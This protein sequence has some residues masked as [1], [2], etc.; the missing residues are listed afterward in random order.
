MEQEKQKTTCSGT[1]EQREFHQACSRAGLI[2][3]CYARLCVPPT[4][5]TPPKWRSCWVLT[6]LL[7]VLQ[8]VCITWSVTLVLSTPRLYV[9][10][11][12][13]Y[14]L[15]YFI[16]ISLHPCE[17]EKKF[18]CDH[19]RKRK[20]LDNPRLPKGSGNSKINKMIIFLV[21]QTIIEGTI[22]T[23]SRCV[24]RHKRGCQ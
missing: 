6:S 18:Q 9:Y 5:D 21:K 15:I 8:L 19:M 20:S 12:V 24:H 3:D 1:L 11:C 10:Y 22:F 16:W 17:R 13:Y 7:P 23:S 2:G 14:P 4:I